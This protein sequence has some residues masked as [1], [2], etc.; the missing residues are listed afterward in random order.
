MEEEREAGERKGGGL[1]GE[2][3]LQADVA[4]VGCFDYGGCAGAGRRGGVSGGLEVWG[5]RGIQDA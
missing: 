4:E 3:L 2:V 5:G 1:T